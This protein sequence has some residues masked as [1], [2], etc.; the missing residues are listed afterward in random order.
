MYVTRLEML[1][2]RMREEEEGEWQIP[3]IRVEPR[4]VFGKLPGNTRREGERES[5]NDEA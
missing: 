4:F 1:H 3:T 2:S 5:L